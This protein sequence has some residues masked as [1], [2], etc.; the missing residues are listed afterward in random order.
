MQQNPSQP[1]KFLQEQPMQMQFF[2]ITLLDRDSPKDTGFIFL[3]INHFVENH[4][5]LMD[6][7]ALEAV[8][9]CCHL[10]KADNVSF[11]EIAVRGD[12]WLLVLSLGMCLC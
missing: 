4:Q 5:R 7:L 2:I 10:I 12:L 11:N 3:H 1:A 8:P 9:G 6:G